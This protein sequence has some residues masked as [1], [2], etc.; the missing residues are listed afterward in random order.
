MRQ[1]PLVVFLILLPHLS[2][3]KDLRILW[4]NVK[5][6]SN[7]ESRVQKVLAEIGPDYDFIFLGESRPAVVQQL[8]EGSLSSFGYSQSFDYPDNAGVSISVLSKHPIQLV[9]DLTLDWGTDQS[10]ADWLKRYG[11]PPANPRRRLSVVAAEISGQTFYFA[12]VHFLNPWPIMTS[13]NGVVDTALDIYVGGENPLLRQTV[14]ALESLE[15]N[16]FFND[17]VP[18]VLIGD[19]NA[20]NGPVTSHIIRTIEAHLSNL[21]LDESA[22]FPSAGLKIDHAFSTRRVQ[23]LEDRVL[24]HEG[25]DHYPIE[26]VISDQLVSN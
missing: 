3:A 26:I 15:K 24:I 22:S 18:F 20:P 12:P 7:P 5:G 14:Q 11:P 4:W 8:T 13:I 1:I 19:F 16:G 2:H 25:S 17:Q 9:Q 23:S 21:M 6:F 10:K